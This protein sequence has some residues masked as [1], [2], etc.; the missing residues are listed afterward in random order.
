MF[1]FCPT[2]FRNPALLP[3]TD[4]ICQVLHSVTT[5]LLLIPSRQ[6]FGVLLVCH[7]HEYCC[8][9]CLCTCSWDQVQDFLVTLLQVQQ[10]QVRGLVAPSTGPH[11]DKSLSEVIAPI[12]IPI[13]VSNV[14]LNNYSWNNFQP[15]ITV[16]RHPWMCGSISSVLA[17]S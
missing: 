4:F 3:V 10:Q 5:Q 9:N 7:I 1:L 16:K 13:P 2:L 6:A 8:S 11:S 12:P 14:Q 15:E 17:A